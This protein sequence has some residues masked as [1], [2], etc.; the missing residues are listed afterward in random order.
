MLDWPEHNQTSPII[1]LVNVSFSPSSKV[2]VNGPPALGVL[3]LTF[4][5]PSASML[6][7]IFWLFQDG[8]IVMVLFGAPFPQNVVMSFCCNTILSVIT[9][10]NT[11]K[12]FALKLKRK[13][14]ENINRYLN[15]VFMFVI[16]RLRT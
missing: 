12:A 6:P 8:I 1:M 13:E 14:I 15:C 5:L 9:S 10:G 4:Q 3:I 2:M 11:I 7:V 16:N